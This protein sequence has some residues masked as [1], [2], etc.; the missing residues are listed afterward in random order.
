MLFRSESLLSLVKKWGTSALIVK[1]DQML[2]MIAAVHGK[3]DRKLADAVKPVQDYLNQLARRLDID[4]D[5]AH[6]A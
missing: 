4:A 3:A 2:E 6:R 1:A 5:M